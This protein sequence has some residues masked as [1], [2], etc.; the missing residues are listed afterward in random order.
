MSDGGAAAVVVSG[1]VE[2]PGHLV[3]AFESLPF[4]DYRATVRFTNVGGLPLAIT[5]LDAP[6]LAYAP[7]PDEIGAGESLD[8]EVAICAGGAPLP[9]LVAHPNPP[10]PIP[11]FQI[12]SWVTVETDANTESTQL[13][14]WTFGF[15]PPSCE[16]V[17]EP[18]DG[19][20]GAGEP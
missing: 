1:Q 4:V 5:G 6:G 14:G 2:K 20:L 17:F 19:L 16:T 13:H 8:L 15:A 3:A 10:Q 11:M 7:L 9:V 12:A 18:I